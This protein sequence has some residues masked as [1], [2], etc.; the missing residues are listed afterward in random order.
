MLR[1]WICLLALVGQACLA[2]EVSPHFSR[3]L[4]PVMKLYQSGQW[5]QA[6]S[7]AS[8]LKPNS[9]AERAWLAQLQ[10][11]LAA[12]LQQTTQASRYVEQA[13]A[14]KEWPEQ[15]QLQLLRLRG[16]IQAQ[17]SNWSGA[18]ASYKAALA[19]KQ[20]DALRLRL[21]GLYY[22]NKQYGDA[23]NQSEQL[24]K[25]GWQKQAAII[26]L[27]ALTAQ[28]RY[29][30]AADQAVELIR[31]EPT[32]SKWWQQAVSLNLS[33]KRGDQALALLQ[34]AIDR[35]LMDDASARNQL[36]RLYAWQGLPYRGARLLEAAMAKGQMKQSAENRQL[37]AQ[38]WEGAREWSQAVDSWQQL[39]NQHGQPKAA[40]R[41]AELLLQQGKTDAAMIQLAAIKSVKGEQG[42]RAKALL[43]QAHLNKEQYAQALELARELQQQDN[44]QQK[45][46]SWVNYIRAQSEELS[47]KAA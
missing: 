42:N 12:N 13:L 17:Q 33:A 2:M 22:H 26:R 25:K 30:V 43:V 40:M 35:K 29:G 3:Q 21:A 45:A 31:H 27:S 1:I 8:G 47:K 44:W 38:L 19:L 39:A 16:D 36:I 41:A 5:Q 23:A 37:L 24:L 9:D 28:Q 20:D 10:A 46:T 32:E 15:Q 4:E 6:Q 18:I 11:S 7:K 34:T 14:Y